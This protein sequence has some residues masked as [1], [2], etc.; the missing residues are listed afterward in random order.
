M[1][2]VHHIIDVM[3]AAPEKTEHPIEEVFDRERWSL[4]ELEDLYENAPIGYA[5][6]TPEGILIRCNRLFREWLG[7]GERCRGRERI[8]RFLAPESQKIF[9]AHLAQILNEGGRAGCCSLVLLGKEGT[10]IPVRVESNPYVEGNLVQRL[11]SAFIDITPQV[12]AEQELERQLTVLRS[13]V[14]LL[15]SE[16]TTEEALFEFVL[17]EALKIA[18]CAKGC[19]YTYHTEGSTIALKTVACR[20]EGSLPCPSPSRPLIRKLCSGQFSH[21]QE[22]DLLYIPLFHRRLFVG[23]LI[24][25]GPHLETPEPILLQL[26]LLIRTAWEKL[27]ERDVK[28]HRETYYRAVQGIHQPVVITDPQGN[29]E[30]VNEAFLRMYGF[31]REEVLGQTPRVLNPGVEVYRNLGYT[32][33]EY[34]VLFRTMWKRILDPEDGQWEGILVNRKKSGTLVWVQLTISAIRDS[35]GRIQHFIGLPVDISS[36]KENEYRTR[37]DLYRTIARLSELRDNETGNH[38]RRVGIYARLLAKALGMPE[39]FCE[40]MELFAP[41]HD[42]GKVGISDTILLVN[43]PLTEEEYAEIKKHTLL[44]YNIVRDKEELR[45]ASDII[46]YHHERWDGTGYPYGLKAE[47]I[48]LS[49]RITAIAD[50]YDALRSKR[51]YK[52]EWP[53][54]QAVAEIVKGSGKAFDPRLVQVF[55]QLAG[56]FDEVY[57]KLKD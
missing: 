3:D 45:T 2:K 46:L 31:D 17:H 50:V 21:I 7:L 52:E 9:A 11:R 41:M 26:N 30:E 14:A 38:M 16:V 27:E 39:K 34:K 22:G 28:I 15:K 12:H 40:E 4:Q 51:P 6:Y 35:S 10:P 47:A 19:L 57:T 53:Q 43:R 1:H 48:P 55:L 42:I 8:Q 44:G 25:E 23:L 56:Q 13:L 24:L 33:E 54:E 5:T 49:A 32:R 37:I 20:M 18:S 29:I 36:L